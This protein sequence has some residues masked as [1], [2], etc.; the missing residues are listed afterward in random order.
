MPRGG[1]PISRADRRGPAT[2][3][4]SQIAAQRAWTRPPG[5]PTVTSTRP[6]GAGASPHDQQITDLPDAGD[7]TP[8]GRAS[9][10]D[11]VKIAAQPPTLPRDG[12]DP[13]RPDHVHNPPSLAQTGPLATPRP[14]HSPLSPGLLQAELA[15]VEV[16]MLGRGVVDV[17]ERRELRK[18]I[19]SSRVMHPRARSA[20]AS[21][22]QPAV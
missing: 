15:V 22:V 19:P 8:S 13:H 9:K 20:S 2:P 18:G 14:R 6:I 5:Q 3:L 4:V 11:V 1:T 7:L 16:E 12:R 10:P 17:G 21:G